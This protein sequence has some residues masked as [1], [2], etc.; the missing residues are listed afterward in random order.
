MNSWSD[1]VSDT[2]KSQ[3]SK[4]NTSKIDAENLAGLF[5]RI[6]LMLEKIKKP[7]KKLME[8]FGK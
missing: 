3:L 1:R 8:P 7:Q 4:I 5:H 6:D 2:S